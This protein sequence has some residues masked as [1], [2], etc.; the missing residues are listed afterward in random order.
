MWTAIDSAAG[1][2][3]GGN[4]YRDP[5][6]GPRRIAPNAGGTMQRLLRGTLLLA[7][8]AQGAPA[9]AAQPA[10][11]DTAELRRAFAGV[12][13]DDFEIVGTELHSGL[14]ERS[15]TFWLAHLRPRH[16]GDYQIRYTHAY[17]DRVRLE[18]PL[19]THVEHTATIRVGEAGCLRR[20][21]A[22][23]ACLGDVVIVPV[24]AGDAAGPF[25]DHAFEL[26]RRGP[27][28]DSPSARVQAVHH[29]ISTPAEPQLRLV[30]TRVDEM[31]HRSLGATVEGNAVFEAAEPGALTLSLGGREVPVVVVARGTPVTVLLRNER[32]RSY[33]ATDGFSSHTGNQYLTD[34][35]LLQPG[36]RVSLPFLHRTIHGADF[37][38]EER[39]AFRRAV[40]DVAVHPFR[41]AV[42]ERFNAFLAAHLPVANGAR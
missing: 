9:L 4:G 20:A 16:S 12:L 41:V 30:G 29:P 32:V 39:E 18:R 34:V 8:L 3:H 19:Y 24:V 42:E 15:G 2:I 27:G 25:A 11:P 36:D 33:H 28:Q 40:P 26:T 21:R 17:I 23:D 14:R 35:L 37:T 13:G 31:P 1:N 22:W 6:D 38:A 7:A 5:V 10:L